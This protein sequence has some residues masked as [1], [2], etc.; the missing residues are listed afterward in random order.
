MSYV[1][2]LYDCH[3]IIVDNNNNFVKEHCKNLP[4]D[5]FI[6]DEFCK[7][8]NKAVHDYLLNII[9][10]ECDD[11]ISKIIAKPMDNHKSGKPIATT[12]GVYIYGKPY[13]RFTKKFK[14]KVFDFMSSQYSDGWGEG[15][16]GPVN[17][18]T[19]PDGTRLYVD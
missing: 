4:H 8:F 10:N 3:E 15:F 5:Q 17:I 1:I 2:S 9:N 16:F 7:Q 12:V 14:E 13:V 18:M 11:K 6:K 19:A